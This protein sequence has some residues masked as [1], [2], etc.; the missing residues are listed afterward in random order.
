MIIIYIIILIYNVW[1]CAFHFACKWCS[2]GPWRRQLGDV[3]KALPLSLLQL[4]KLRVFWIV[5]SQP[6][7]LFGAIWQ[8]APVL[9]RPTFFVWTW[10]ACNKLTTWVQVLV[11]KRIHTLFHCTWARRGIQHESRGPEATPAVVT[12]PRLQI[13]HKPCH[14]LSQTSIE[15]PKC[16]PKCSPNAALIWRPSGHQSNPGKALA[17]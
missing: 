12:I 6:T 10:A 16:S 8:M 14:F 1:V 3:G 15:A 9:L 13:R 2:N 4:V 11:A 7:D 5:I 17:C